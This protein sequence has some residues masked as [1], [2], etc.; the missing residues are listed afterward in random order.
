MKDETTNAEHKAARTFDITPS[1][2]ALRRMREVFRSTMWNAGQK[3]VAAEKMLGDGGACELVID[4]HDDAELVCEALEALIERE[5]GRIGHMK[6]G[7]AEVDKTG[8]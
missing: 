3:I 8:V 7:I 6:D 2:E 1:P 5:L 4:N